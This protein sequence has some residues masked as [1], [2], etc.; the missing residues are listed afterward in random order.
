MGASGES[1]APPEHVPY[2]DHAAVDRRKLT[3]YLLSS[4]HPLGSAKSRFFSRLGFRPEEIDLLR[5][6]LIA[7]AAAN[8]VAAREVSAFGAKYVVD[9]PIESPSGRKVSIRAVWFAERDETIPRFVTAYPL[10]ERTS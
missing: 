7:H 5:E 3:D 8:P 10:K 4:A 6:A 1:G 2:L 9:G